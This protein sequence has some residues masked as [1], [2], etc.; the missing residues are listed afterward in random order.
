M[1]KN[2]LYLAFHVSLHEAQC[3]LRLMT[4]SVLLSKIML[5]TWPFIIEEFRLNRGLLPEFFFAI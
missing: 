2:R 4:Y 3:H 1:V 5:H